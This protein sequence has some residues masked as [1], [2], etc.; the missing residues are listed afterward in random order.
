[1][2]RTENNYNAT[3]EWFDVDGKSVSLEMVQLLADPSKGG[4]KRVFRA[5]GH[6]TS[7]NGTS[8]YHDEWLSGKMSFQ[9][10]FKMYEDNG[11][12]FKQALRG[13]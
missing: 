5:N 3:C 13:R 10:S 2:S 4:E 12:R 1:M 9:H 6:W 11:A 7:N 8:R